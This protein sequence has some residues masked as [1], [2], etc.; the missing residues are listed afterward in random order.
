MAVAIFSVFVYAVKPGRPSTVILL[1]NLSAVASAA[2]AFAGGLNII[3][4][5]PDIQAPG[6]WLWLTVGLGLFLAGE[7]SWAFQEVVLGIKSPFPSVADIFWLAGYPPLMIGLVIAW[8]QL[9]IALRGGEILAIGVGAGAAVTAGAFWL[10][11]P[12]ATAPKLPPLE[13]ILDFAYPLADILL[14]IPAVALALIF[15]RSLLGRPWRLICVGLVFM[16]LADFS[17][18]YLTWNN[19]YAS[20]S[21]NLIDL[22]WVVGYLT[23][24]AGAF[25]YDQV[26][27]GLRIR[28]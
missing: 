25:Y 26:M 3:R 18:A 12:I 9:D 19:M 23:I 21:G 28:P 22:L 16:G 4:R 15:G 1:T 8:R 14:I 27:N 20:Q 17:F 6:A 7:I 11:I 5:R 13:K 10:L 2:V 24:A